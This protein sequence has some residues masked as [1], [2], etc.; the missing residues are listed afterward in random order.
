MSLDFIWERMASQQKCCGNDKSDTFKPQNIKTFLKL[1]SFS[2]LDKCTQMDVLYQPAVL[3][4]G[5]GRGF[6]FFF[7]KTL[8]QGE[9]LF[10][11]LIFAESPRNFTVFA[12][13]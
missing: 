11:S 1:Q 7:C 6:F 8:Q 9:H 2:S 5:L 12:P 13:S 4:G 10:L 3:N